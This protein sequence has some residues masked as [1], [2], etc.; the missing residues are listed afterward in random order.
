M[1]GLDTGGITHLCASLADRHRFYLDVPSITKSIVGHVQ[2]SLARQAYNLDDFGAY[3]A[4]A[5]SV[6][7]NLIV[8]FC[9]FNSTDSKCSSP[10]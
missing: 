10:C 5:L 7:D 9:T 6:R 4:A 3:Q 1:R 2:T 8:C